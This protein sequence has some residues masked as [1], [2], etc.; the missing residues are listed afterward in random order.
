MSSPNSSSPIW[1]P[2]TQHALIPDATMVL[3]GEGV[4]LETEKGP[5]LDAISSWWVITH[6]HRHP[7]IIEAIRRQ[8]EELD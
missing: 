6:G 8:T 1:H 3:R 7:R 5:L 4:W 2:F